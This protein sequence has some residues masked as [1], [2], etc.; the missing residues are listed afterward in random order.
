MIPIML[1]PNEDMGFGSIKEVVKFF[2]WRNKTFSKIV[3]EDADENVKEI[4]RRLLDSIEEAFEIGIM[5]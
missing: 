4:N 5:K 1:N 3:P 2:K